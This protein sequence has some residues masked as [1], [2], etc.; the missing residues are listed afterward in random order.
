MMYLRRRGRLRQR[1]RMSSFEELREQKILL[2]DAE[3]VLP[4]LRDDRRKEFLALFAEAGSD[5]A[6][7]RIAI[8]SA[9]NNIPQSDGHPPISFWPYGE[10]EGVQF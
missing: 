10:V 7:M 4:Y 9:C 3:T 8:A 6:K 1:K 5:I 2:E